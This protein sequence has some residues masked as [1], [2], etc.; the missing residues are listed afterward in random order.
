[1]NIC[2]NNKAEFALTVFAQPA[3][4]AFCEHSHQLSL[5]R[6][7][8]RTRDC[9]NTHISMEIMSVEGE[10]GSL[11]TPLPSGEEPFPNPHPDQRETCGVESGWPDC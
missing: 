6:R 8:D 2:L 4:L 10:E 1:M 7:H 5:A 3:F 9:C 11:R